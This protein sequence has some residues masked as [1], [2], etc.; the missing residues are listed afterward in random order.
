MSNVLLCGLLLACGAEVQPVVCPAWSDFRDW[1][2][3]GSPV[4]LHP[5]ACGRYTTANFRGHGEVRLYRDQGGIVGA[6]V[7]SDCAD[8]VLQI[9]DV[10]FHGRVGELYTSAAVRA[11]AMVRL[12]LPDS[13]WVSLRLDFKL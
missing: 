12:A 1:T 7:L 3:Q 9:G 5:D 11:P 13:C 2:L 10:P 4:A 6:Q 8:Y